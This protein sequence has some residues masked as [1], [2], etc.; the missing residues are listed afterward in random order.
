MNPLVA[1]YAP[2]ALILALAGGLLAG[3][4]EHE[5]EVGRLQVQLQTAD[6]L[7]RVAVAEARDWQRKATIDSARAAKLEADTAK[8]NQ[9][10]RR[11][12]ARYAQT[13]PVLASTRH[14]L[15][16][17]MQVAQQH[18]DSASSGILA[19][20]RPYLAKSDSTIKACSDALTAEEQA[21]ASCQAQGQAVKAQLL[22]VQ[23][24]VRALQKDTLAKSI[25]IRGL[26]QERPSGFSTWFWRV[27]PAV[28]VYFI[29]RRP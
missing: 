22:D 2:Y 9:T 17:A 4:V 5:R 15:D 11:A 19:L 24:T 16:S 13:L 6:S 25:Q 27:A 28:V 1:K 8:A 20:L 21:L 12:T 18:P 23:G 14:A 29:A 3:F 26:R 7:H 10:A